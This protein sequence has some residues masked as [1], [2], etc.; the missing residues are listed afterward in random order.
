[1]PRRILP[2]SRGAQFDPAI[3]DAFLQVADAFTRESER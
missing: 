1:M 2:I 3:V